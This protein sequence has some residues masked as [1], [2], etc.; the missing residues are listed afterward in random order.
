MSND[1][2]RKVRAPQ[3]EDALLRRPPS[4]MHRLGSWVRDIAYEI[5]PSA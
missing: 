3:G 5:V 1:N 4:P 2:I